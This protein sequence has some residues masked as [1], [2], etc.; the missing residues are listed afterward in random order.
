MPFLIDSVTRSLGHSV[1]VANELS[2]QAAASTPSSPSRARAGVDT[3]DHE[4]R[5]KVLLNTLMPR[6]T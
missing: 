3:S 4:L 6:A 5:I 2:R 1:S